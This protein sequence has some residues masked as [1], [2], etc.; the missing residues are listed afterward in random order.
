MGTAQAWQRKRCPPSTRAARGAAFARCDA[1]LRAAEELFAM[2]NLAHLRG[3]ANALRLTQS[4]RAAV[5]AAR[6]VLS[7]LED[8]LEEE[9]QT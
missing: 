4:A 9:K 6:R 2:A 3:R 7:E 8:Y 5:R 1:M